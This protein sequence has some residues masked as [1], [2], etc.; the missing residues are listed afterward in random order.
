MRPGQLAG[1]T[2]I[3]VAACVA[4]STPST[5][6]TL[7]ASPTAGS[8]ATPTGTATVGPTVSTAGAL[9]PSFGEGGLVV[10]H[11]ADSGGDS[12]RAV[13]IDADGRIVV[14]GVSGYQ[15]GT[16]AVLARYRA[17][18]SIDASFGSGGVVTTDLGGGAWQSIAV[19][20]DGRVIA[21]GES[22]VRGK[23]PDFAL[24]RY[25]AD[26]SLDSSFGDGG[27]VATDFPGPSDDRAWAL[28]IDS[29]GRVVVGGL[30]TIFDSATG[31][32]IC[33]R[34]ALA[35][36]AEH[37]TLDP[38]F[39]SGGLV[40]TDADSGLVADALAIDSAGRIVVAS[41]THGGDD[42][43]EDAK[44]AVARYTTDG[45]LDQT[46]GQDGLV[47]TDFSGFAAMAIDADGRILVGGT[48]DDEFAVARYTTDG[49]LDQ[50]FGQA[51]GV[52]TD[53]GEFRTL[54]IDA[55]GRTVVAGTSDADFAVARYTA[56]GTPDQ[57]FGQGGL[58]LT[59]FSG[60]GSR[61]VGFAMTI[62]AD[63]RI[64]LVGE[65]EVG[66][67]EVTD[68]EDLDFALARYLSR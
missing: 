50:T 23:N 38:S 30:S 53:F 18:G 46:F 21:A 1:V 19:A 58:V 60:S 2:L 36:Y 12:L 48:S 32:G 20:Q 10:T 47:I 64:V 39:G 49:S 33:C 15:N 68:W 56:D 14:A 51:G 52:T 22:I 27:L 59:D 5:A 67:P 24:A 40:T 9:D 4:P 34:L 55:D 7:F 65:T 37:G 35:R 17:D 6:E 16:Y 45:S 26:G 54:T 13:A 57:T 8:V 11:L 42:A 25:T 41:G 3:L 31:Q 63:G 66:D 62:D 43:N 61:D 28:A 29:D 44:I